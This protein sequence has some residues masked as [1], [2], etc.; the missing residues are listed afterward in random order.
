[1]I[2]GTSSKAV[3]LARGLGT[4]MRRADDG[5]L[6][7]NPQAA[8]A[9]TGVKALI[10][11]RRPFLDYVLSALADAECGR[12][13]LVVGPE[14][15]ALREYYQRQGELTRVALGDTTQPEP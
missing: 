13:C 8:A 9:E 6:L 3:I 14:H 5:V 12:V 4:R 10:P 11:M 1:M 7:A 15:D 2:P